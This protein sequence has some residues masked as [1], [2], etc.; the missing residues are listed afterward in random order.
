MTIDESFL[1][2]TSE[3]YQLPVA[4]VLLE[5]R[6]GEFLSNSLAVQR[7]RRSLR[8]LFEDDAA[9]LDEEHETALVV[10]MLQAALTDAAI[11][12]KSTPAAR[13]RAISTTLEY[14]LEHP[15]EAVS[16][17][18]LC[19]A[20]G[21]AFRTLSRAFRERFDVSPKTYLKQARLTGVRSD[22]IEGSASTKIA[23]VANDWGFWHMGQ[24]ARDYRKFFG[25]LPSE[26]LRR[27]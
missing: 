21:V 16:V 13:A 25:E 6:S 1:I 11:S 22:L 23:D 19:A 2:E 9:R 5:P 3:T 10:D 14:C 18:E 20:T 7:V 27:S 12:D 24:F 26:T 17:R 15:H 8:K 4:E